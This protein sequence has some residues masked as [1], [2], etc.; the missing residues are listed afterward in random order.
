MSIILLIPFF[1]GCFV[2]L[3]LYYLS[4]WWGFVFIF[5]W[6]GFSIS[7][8]Q[9]LAML[10]KAK[11][12]DIGRRIAILA[13]S[14]VF[15]VFLGIIQRENL[16]LEETIFY[17][18]YGVFT[19]VLIHYAIAKILGPFIWGRGFCG[20]ACWTAALLE[21]LPL[22]DNRK[23][24]KR[25]TYIRFP[26]LVASILVPLL[27]IWSGYDYINL[28]IDESN[29]K[30]HQLIWFLAG[31]GLYYLAAVILAFVFRKKRAFCKIVCP[32]SLIM[33]LQ[34]RLAL[35]KM[36]PSNIPCRECGLCNKNCPMDIDVMSYISRGNKVSSTE[37][38]LC[39]KCKNSCPY[40]AIA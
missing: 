8:G 18:G 13:I 39:G 30:L 1:I 17:L 27:F 22:K 14:P 24:P 40:G 9:I 23:I 21:W 19:R 28:H 37:C 31:N 29:G 32:V 6:I 4:H 12:K 16:Q 38:I 20:W 25:L 3:L 15:L 2:A 33:K 5:T 11:D 36:K 7:A 34:S 35:I 10:L 26:V